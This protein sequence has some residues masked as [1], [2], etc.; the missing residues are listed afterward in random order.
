MESDSSNRISYSKKPSAEVT[1]PRYRYQINDVDWNAVARIGLNREMLEKCYVLDEFLK[2]FKT[3]VL[4]PVRCDDLEEGGTVN[5]R[6]QL[7][8][9]DN[10]EVMLHV[11]QS[12]KMPDFRKK[13]LGHKFSKK[14]R[15]NL[16]NIGNMGRVVQLMNPITGEAIPSLISRDKLTNELFSLPI[17]FVRIP[18]V[19]CGVVLSSEQQEVLRL[20]KP[21]FIEICFLKV[22]G[23]SMRLCSLMQKS[24]GWSFSL[25]R[26]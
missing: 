17:N 7:K 11:H 18:A 2:G 14:D 8:L 22:R 10:G 20:G 23:F 13:F 24:S 15:L 16:L 5:A 4:L 19:V 3:S 25:T 1:N 12:Q 9:N 6:L 21:L 26:N